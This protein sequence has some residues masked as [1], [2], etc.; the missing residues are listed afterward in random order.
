MPC[1]LTLPFTHIQDGAFGRRVPL[2]AFQSTRRR[3]SG[4]FLARQAQELHNGKSKFVNMSSSRRVKPLVSRSLAHHDIDSVHPSLQEV[5]E[6]KIERPRA[7]SNLDVAATDIPA[8]VD[9]EQG[10]LSASLLVEENLASENFA[11]PVD[12]TVDDGG[13]AV[14]ST[15]EK[16][17]AE[18]TSVTETD[19]EK[20]RSFDKIESKLA[21]I[22]VAP[23][24]ETELAATTT[25]DVNEDD[26]SDGGSS[27]GD[28]ME[29]ISFDGEED[30]LISLPLAG[31][32]RHDVLPDGVNG[33][34]RKE[35]NGCAICLCAFDATDK[36]TWSSNPACQH[37]FHDTC[38][39]G[40]L[41]ASGRKNLKKQ[42]RE[43][44]RSGNMSYGSN[45]VGKIIGFPKLCPCCRQHFIMEEEEEDSV[46]EKE[47]R[48][49]GDTE[50]P[51]GAELGNDEAMRIAAS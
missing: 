33:S 31:E 18:E 11:N 19:L 45:P 4:I 27:D 30:G 12:G 42:R 22:D 6:D 8:A 17:I 2:L 23:I 20:G 24:G 43:Q 14:K 48:A 3:N 7:N 35:P 41:V 29:V 34:Y 21:N 15:M 44:R 16:K 32:C 38:I 50:N 36:I 26:M 25:E 46:D 51:G 10:L 40:W 5:T 37:V 13:E 1:L 9:L 49:I 28:M 47:T 39:M